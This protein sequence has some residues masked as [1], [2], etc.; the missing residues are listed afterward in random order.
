MINVL[1]GD[2]SLVGP[3][4]IVP[5][6]KRKYRDKLNDRLA[7]LPGMTGYWQVHGRSEIDYEHRIKMDLWYIHNWS[8]WLDIMILFKTIEIVLKRK[9]AY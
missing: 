3:R 7:V 6:E 5:D 1:R 8:V 2:M 4:Q 9:G